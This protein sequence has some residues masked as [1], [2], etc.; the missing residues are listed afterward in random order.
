MIEEFY[1]IELKC[2]TSRCPELIRVTEP[3]RDECNKLLYRLGWR[4]LRDKHLCPRHV[5]IRA[6][7][8]DRAREAKKLAPRVRGRK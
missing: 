6:K 2:D 3:T 8:R 1:L 7:R 4:V 5:A